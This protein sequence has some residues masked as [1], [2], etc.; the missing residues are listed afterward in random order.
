MQLLAHGMQLLSL[1]V[2]RLRC[3]TIVTCATRLVALTTAL[4]ILGFLTPTPT[5]TNVHYTYHFYIILH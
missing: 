4:P 3:A 2:L 5:L 1:L